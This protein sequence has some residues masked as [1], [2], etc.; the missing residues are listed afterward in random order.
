[1]QFNLFAE[2]PITT[3]SATSMPWEAVLEVHDYQ[4]AQAEAQEEESKS[5]RPSAAAASTTANGSE[6]NGHAQ[7][8]QAKD[9][10]KEQDEQFEDRMTLWKNEDWAQLKDRAARGKKGPEEAISPWAGKN[11]VA[12]YKIGSKPARCESDSYTYRLSSPLRVE[13]NSPVH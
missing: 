6:A 13:E 7:D 4:V 3:V 2:D 5:K 10:A 1:M 12:V 9:H 11:P 8:A